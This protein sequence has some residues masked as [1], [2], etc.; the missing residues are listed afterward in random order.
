MPKDGTWLDLPLAIIMLQAAA[1]VFA[2]RA[3]RAMPGLLRGFAAE[4]APA[5]GASTDVGYVSQVIGERFLFSS[6]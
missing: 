3:G 1:G 4:A 2:R 6:V 5:A